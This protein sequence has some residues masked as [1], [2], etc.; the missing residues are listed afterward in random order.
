MIGVG[1]VGL[2]AILA[3]QAQGAEKVSSLFY[4]QDTCLQG[5]DTPCGPHGYPSSPGSGCREGNPP[6]G[7]PVGFP[8]GFPVDY[9]F[10]GSDTPCFII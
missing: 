1:S 5:S 7:F 8:L 9:L 3:A 10:R 6:V 4:F 2:M